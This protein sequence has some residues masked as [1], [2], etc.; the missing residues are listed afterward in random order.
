MGKGVAWC[1]GVLSFSVS[2]SACSQTIPTVPTPRF[3]A[4][5]QTDPTTTKRVC[6]LPFA[7]KIQAPRLANQVRQSFAGHLS[8]KHF[9]DA[10]LHDIDARLETLGVGWQ[11]VSAQDL[12][13]ALNCNAL[14]YGEVTRASRLY[15]ALYSQL[16]LEGNILLVDAETGQTLVKDAYATKFRSADFPLSPLSIVPDAIKNL[17]NLS[18]AQ[19]VRAIDDLGRNLANKV[20]D[21]PALPTYESAAVPSAQ[22]NAEHPPTP[23]LPASAFIAEKENLP[24]ARTVAQ[25]ESSTFD[26]PPTNAPVS[27]NQTP[28]VAVNSVTTASATMQNEGYHLQVAALRTPAKAQR[29]AHLLRSK[30]YEPIVAQSVGTKPIWHRVVLGPFP[31]IHSAQEVGAQINKALRFSPIVIN[32]PHP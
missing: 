25:L 16:T 6:V 29:V 24:P 17:H 26:I 10:E 23:Q 22:P 31:S 27:E 11:T 28:G 18:D 30:G 13:K 12:G 9:A 8:I 7:D 20:P 14:V 4:W 21:V 5:S 3:I 1:A 19:M 32:Q 2:I 15:L